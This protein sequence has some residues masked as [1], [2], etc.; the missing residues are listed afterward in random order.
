MKSAPRREP[1]LTTDE[2]AWERLARARVA[3]LAALWG[4]PGAADAFT[5]RFSGRLSRSLGRADSASGRVTLATSLR[6][7]EELL[8]QALSH[9]LAHLIAFFLVG[10]AEPAHGPTW[11][12]LMRLAGHQPA[13]RL[14]SPAVA[15]AGA[16]PKEAR[17]YRH[18]CP[19]C[20]FTR[21]ASRRMPRWRCADC[22]ASGLGG[23]LEIESEGRLR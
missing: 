19:V 13:I 2:S 16:E 20:Q 9:E 4:V 1:R 18:R 21:T 5:V 22:A 17:R 15:V 6:G 12:R 10:R 14:S 7:D 11:K 8:D 23:R 3:E